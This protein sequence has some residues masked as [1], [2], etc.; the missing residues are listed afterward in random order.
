MDRFQLIAKE[1]YK[2]RKE[3]KDDGFGIL[4]EAVSSFFPT[5]VSDK[6]IP[7]EMYGHIREEYLRDNATVIKPGDRYIRICGINV[8]GHFGV[9]RYK[10]NIYDLVE[11][12]SPLFEE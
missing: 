11:E 9:W 12:I 1:I 8:D 10:P 6:G 5:G 2:A 3:Y 4:C 7:Q